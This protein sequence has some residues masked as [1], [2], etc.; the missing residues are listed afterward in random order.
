VDVYE[1][2]AH[3]LAHIRHLVD[4]TA[5][6]DLASVSPAELHA[7]LIAIDKALAEAEALHQKVEY[8]S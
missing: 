2:L 1:Q 6:C 4:F 7:Q 8:P 5:S 3:Q